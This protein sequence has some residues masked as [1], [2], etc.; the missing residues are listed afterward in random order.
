VLVV[1]SVYRTSFE[2]HYSGFTSTNG[3]LIERWSMQKMYVE[4][5][6][7]FPFIHLVLSM[8]VSNPRGEQFCVKPSGAS[9]AFDEEVEHYN[10]LL[11][12]TPAT[13][14]LDVAVMRSRHV[15]AGDK[16]SK[17]MFGIPGKRKTIGGTSL[18]D[19][20]IELEQLMHSAM[21][22]V[23]HTPVTMTRDFFFNFVKP[24]SGVGSPCDICKT[25]MAFDKH[26]TEMSC[27]V[28][29]GNIRCDD[30]LQPDGV[31]LRDD[32][33]AVSNDEMICGNS[34]SSA[35]VRLDDINNDDDDDDDDGVLLSWEDRDK[36]L[37][38]AIRKL[39]NMH[40]KPLINMQ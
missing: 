38:A 6:A 29:T 18:E 11:K 17:E 19:D 21:V 27:R 25:T 3:Y 32:M 22:F 16:A 40:R 35:A 34:M 8:T 28:L 26:E 31:C 4:M 7:I 23:D 24:K 2:S 33:S 13:P 10:N 5:R 9:V 20:I 15:V 36:A 14:S 12:K 37:E 1:D 39:G 30:E